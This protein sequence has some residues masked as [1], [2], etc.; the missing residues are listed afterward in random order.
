MENEQNNEMTAQ[1]SLSLIT[2]TLNN[3]RKEITHR[4]GKHFILW[5]ALLTFFSLLVYILCKTTGREVWNWLWFAL[6][7][8]GFPLSRLLFR[9]DTTA[10]VQN[11]VSRI[12]GG[13]WMAFCVFACSVAAFT[14]LYAELSSNIIGVIA[15]T[16]NLTSEIV[17]LFGLAECITGVALKNWVVKIAGIITGIGGITIIYVTSAN[18]EQLFVFTFAGLVLMLTGLIVKLQYK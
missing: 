15:A 13:I 14:M 5:G 3:S 8:I 6:P 4:S 12:T 10:R 1:E 16:V 9:K 17:L 2:E 7:A 18:E 11:D